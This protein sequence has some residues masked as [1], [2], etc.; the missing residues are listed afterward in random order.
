MS[1]SS[2][3]IEVRPVRSRRER[4]TFLTFPWR[5][6]R[7]DPLW[8]PP[9]LPDRAKVID[10]EQGAFFKRGE[11]E[12]F[13]A[14]RGS[15]PVGTIC[16]AEDYHTNDFMGQKNCVFGFF[17]CI[18]DF[19][20]AEALFDAAAGWLR[21]RGM[22]AIRGP[23]SPSQN[24]EVGLLIDGFD[25]PPVIMMTYNPRYY[26]DLIE[27]AGFTKAMDLLAYMV[28]IHKYGPNGENIPPLP[29]FVFNLTFFSTVFKHL[30]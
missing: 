23:E 26:I 22:E 18:E 14:W 7:D 6:Y 29:Y 12:F 21:E 19:A 4:R 30:L 16:A 3:P 10:P 27:S 2:A 17:E 11:A 20:V 25:S 1:T 24:E 28:D 9:L 15:R 13:V 5:V 8:V